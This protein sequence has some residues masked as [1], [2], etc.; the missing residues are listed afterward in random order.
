MANSGFE[1]R[2]LGIGIAISLYTYL[3]YPLLVA[4]TARR[5]WARSQP[6][7]QAH[8]HPLPTMTVVVPAFD[9]EAVIGAK[10]VDTFAQD[11][12]HDRLEVVV[13]ADGS[14]DG[15]A[16]IAR[17]QGVRV[18][19]RPQ[20]QGKSRAVNRGVAAARGE[21]VC[22][23]DANCAL[24]PGSLRRLAAGFADP[25]VAVVSGAKTV[26]GT[27]AKGR[28]EGL[29]WRFESWI[30]Q[31]ESALGCT[32]GAPG[33]ICG[34]RRSLFRPLPPDVIADDY[35]LVCDA[36]ARGYAVRYAPEAVAREDVSDRV[37]DEFER[38]TRIGAGSW[39]TTLAHLRLADPRR[40]WTAVAFVSHRLLRNVVVPSLLPVLW[41]V[42]ARGARKD[43]C[44][45][46]LLWLQSGAWAAAA[47]GAAADEAVL[48]VPFQF[49]LTNLATLRGGWR[50]LTYRQP[51]V[52]KKVRRGA[53]RADHRGERRRY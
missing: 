26:T 36:L 21:L 19:W 52:W 14:S 53:P 20:R 32:M 27:G 18:L 50:Y 25:R 39:Q 1:R 23:S 34:L 47:T 43:R 12:P 16:A 9:E 11:Y 15:T 37:A 8:D 13:V 3:G 28:G 51:A 17:Q 4:L 29:Y 45:R 10:I 48:A 42:S 2:M 38:R 6:A 41:L 7:P 31:A 49:A 40:G 35:H 22:L 44:V 33:E 46:G 24:A 5:R 30:K